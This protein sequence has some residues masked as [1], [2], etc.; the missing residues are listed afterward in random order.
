MPYGLLGKAKLSRLF[1]GGNLVIGCMHC[2]DLRYVNEL[3]RAYM[4]E[5]KI[6]QTFKLAEENGINV[7]FES[8]GDYVARYNK[9]F[10]GH[11]NVIPSIHPDVNQ[12]DTAIKDEIKRNVDAGVPAMYVWGVRADGLVN[13]GRVDVIAKAVDFAKVHNVPVG[14]GGHQ[15]SVVQACEKAKI[16]CDFYVK[17]FHSLDYPS[18]K[19]NCDSV[20]C[21]NPEETAEFMRTVKK[22]WIAYKVLAAGAIAPRQGFANAFRNGADFIAVGMFDFQVKEDC[23]L[24]LR[25]VKMTQKRARP[26]YS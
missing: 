18:A 11:M 15:L 7:V 3:F 21:S 24:M 25:I 10:G 4:T 8:G 5:D 13:T 26:W 20:W 1:L 9:K 12:S 2:R 14:V 17:T 16:P 6:F 19:M 23:A 22:P